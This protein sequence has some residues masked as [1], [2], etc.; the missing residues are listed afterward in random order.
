LR[1]PKPP[2]ISN[3]LLDALPRAERTAVF[4]DCERVELTF[5]DVLCEP[6]DRIR[7]AW[8]PLSG[9]IALIAQVDDHGALEVGSVGNEGLFGVPLALGS[10]RQPL[11]AIVESGGAGAAHRRGA[12]A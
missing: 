2:R 11:R 4:A 5:A 7:H 10:Q 9:S 3:R 8:F 1:R 12:A 6:G